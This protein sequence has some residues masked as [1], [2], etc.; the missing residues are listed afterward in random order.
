VPIAA[1]IGREA[2]PVSFPL[3]RSGWKAALRGLR[4]RPTIPP[5]RGDSARIPRPRC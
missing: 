3:K 2:E 5:P 1:S 4:R